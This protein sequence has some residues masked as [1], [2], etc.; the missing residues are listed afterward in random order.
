MRRSAPRCTSQGCRAPRLVITGRVLTADCAP[1]AGAVLDFWQ[2]DANGVYDN[3]GFTLRGKQ[4]TAE[5]GSYR[6]ETVLP[7]EYPGRP[8]HIHVKVNAP[9]GSALTTQIYFAGQ[10]GNESDG[11]IQPTLITT[12]TT[13]DDGSVSAPFDFVLPQ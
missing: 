9:G 1:V 10:A 4:E 8:P 6:L 2:A 3:V 12:L 13:E 7:G 11:L 5:D